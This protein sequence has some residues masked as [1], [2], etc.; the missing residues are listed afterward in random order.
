MV[1]A[2]EVRSK[3]LVSVVMPWHVLTRYGLVLLGVV[4]AEALVDVP[5]AWWRLVGAVVAAVSL[6]FCVLAVTHLIKAPT[7]LLSPNTE[8]TEDLRQAVEALGWPRDMLLTGWQID[9][10]RERRGG[11]YGFY[12]A[13]IWMAGGELMAAYPASWL[14]TATKGERSYSIIRRLLRTQDRVRSVSGARMALWV[15]G[16]F[17]ASVVASFSIWAGLLLAGMYG[18]WLAVGV[19]RMNRSAA[20]LSQMP[21]SEPELRRK[22]RHAARTG[23]WE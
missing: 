17:L 12:D 23:R 15:G 2:A 16:V 11:E 1:D 21:M 3:N 7:M 18:A 13:A 9:A 10:I 6:T 8:I 4:A 5:A 19:R 22:T 14:S 20:I